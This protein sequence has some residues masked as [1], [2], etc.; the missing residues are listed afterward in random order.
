[1]LFML[2][3]FEQRKKWKKRRKK[4][5]AKGVI[6]I[7]VRESLNSFWLQRFLKNSVSDVGIIFFYDDGDGF[8]G[9]ILIN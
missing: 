8:F 5:E 2:R 6:S 9:V 1:M 4:G 7:V 3:G